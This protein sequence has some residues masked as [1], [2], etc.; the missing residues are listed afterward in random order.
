MI[1]QYSTPIG[2]ETLACLATAQGEVSLM[3]LRPIFRE[4]TL[5]RLVSRDMLKA[6][7][8]AQGHAPCDLYAAVI[9]EAEKA[10]PPSGQEE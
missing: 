10:I 6:L 9:S 4:L 1:T 3:S 2:D 7:K 8:I 5:L